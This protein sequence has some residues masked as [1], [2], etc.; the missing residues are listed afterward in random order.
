MMGLFYTFAGVVQGCRG[1]GVFA[2]TQYSTEGAF[3]CM[4]NRS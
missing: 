1:V 4:E 2:K 3:T